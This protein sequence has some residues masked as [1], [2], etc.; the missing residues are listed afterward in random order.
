MGYHPNY[1]RQG[2]GK[3]RSPGAQRMADRIYKRQDSRN[4]ARAKDWLATEKPG[5]PKHAP[6]SDRPTDK[7]G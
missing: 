5:L 2:Y 6:P 3:M 4:M 7:P 1:G